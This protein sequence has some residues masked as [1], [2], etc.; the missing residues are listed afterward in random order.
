MSVSEPTA[1]SLSKGSIGLDAL[2]SACVCDS[3]TFSCYSPAVPSLGPFSILSVCVYTINATTIIDQVTDFRVTQSGTSAS[4]DSVVSGMTSALTTIT[5]S[6]DK[7]KACIN[8]QLYSN[9]FDDVTAANKHQRKLTAQGSVRV[10]L[11]NGVRR[12][13]S[14]PQSPFHFGLERNVKQRESNQESTQSEQSAFKVDQISLTEKTGS[15]DTSSGGVT[16][17]LAGIGLVVLAALLAVAVVIVKKGS[18]NKKHS[19][20]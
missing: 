6:N 14:I 13:A 7:Q 20:A 3:S 8:T 17:L 2:V 15:S 5:K 4:L 16:G 10:S 18:G 1:G 12:L 9:F 19:F 11:A